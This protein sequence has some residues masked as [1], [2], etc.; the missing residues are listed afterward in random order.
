[1]PAVNFRRWKGIVAKSQ[2]VFMANPLLAVGFVRC[3]TLAVRAVNFR[4]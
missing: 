4:R 1:M 2:C 3:Q